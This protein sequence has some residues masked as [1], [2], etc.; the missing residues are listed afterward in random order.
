MDLIIK[1]YTKESI[2]HVLAF[3]Q[4]LRAEEPGCWC[5]DIGPDYVAAV[6]KSF[7][8]SAFNAS[9]SLLAY[10]GGSVVGRID[11]AMIPSHFDGSRKAY[12][13][14]IC[15]LKSCRHAG[16]A[17]KLLA[18]LKGELKRRGVDTL[19]ALTAADASAQQF[20]RSIPNAVMKDIGIW[21]DV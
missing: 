13:D 21:I 17:Q 12:L 2:P 19:I 7:E 6:E 18:A 9:L 15:V 8:D 14:W 11:A 3:E 20:Y 1:E 10:D 4:R 5:W 16:V